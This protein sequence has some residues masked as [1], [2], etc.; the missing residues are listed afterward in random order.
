MNEF[1]EL[2]N[3]MKHLDINGNEFEKQKQAN[4]KLDRISTKVIQVNGFTIGTVKFDVDTCPV[5]S[6][7]SY[8]LI[9]VYIHDKS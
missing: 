6:Y 5:V 4:L 1:S 3:R 2:F 8:I 7:V 9:C